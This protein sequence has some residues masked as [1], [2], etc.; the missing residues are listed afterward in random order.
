[1][2]EPQV[3]RTP[4][5]GTRSFTAIGTPPS[6]PRGCSVSGSSAMI[7]L[8]WARARSMQ[9]VGIALRCASV[10]AI[11]SALAS[12]SS[13]GETSR[14]RSRSTTSAALSRQRSPFAMIPSSQAA[15]GVRLCQSVSCW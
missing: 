13:S 3:V 8:A 7:R 2:G 11:R 6:Q 14:R 12:T 5:T 15:G 4:S 1:M 9:S 10:A